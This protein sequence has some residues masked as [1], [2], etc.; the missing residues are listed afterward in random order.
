MADQ[1]TTSSADDMCNAIASVLEDHNLMT[2]RKV[3][4]QLVNRGHIAKREEESQTVSR[5]L[6][7]MRRRGTTTLSLHFLS[8]GR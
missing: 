1:I 2:V 7:E 6:I 4:Y 3:F 8:S 5:V